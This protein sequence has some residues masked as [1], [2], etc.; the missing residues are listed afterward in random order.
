[1]KNNL[2]AMILALTMVL[3]LALTGCSSSKTGDSSTTAGTG[4]SSNA[5]MI[6]VGVSMSGEENNSI[7]VALTSGLE[8]AGYTVEVA[9]T[10]DADEQTKQISAMVEDGAKILIV[11]PVNTEKVQKALESIAVDVSDVV[12]IA[13]GDSMDSNAVNVYVGRDEEEFGKQSAQEVLTRLGLVEDTNDD[14]KDADDEDDGETYTVELLSDGGNTSQ[15]AF[16]SAMKVLKPYVD[17]GKL[18]I[19]SGHTTGSACKTEDV[20]STMKSLLTTTYADEEL[21]AILCL[22]RGQAVPVIETIFSSYQGNVYPVIT[23]G[24]VTTETVQYLSTNLLDMVSYYDQAELVSGALSAVQAAI[25][26]K[27]SGEMSVK[28]KISANTAVTA[29]TLDEKLID[30]GLFVRNN[31]GTFSQN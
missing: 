12:V 23:C 30:S 15:V 8:G 13:C 11:D 7:G 14:D 28:E 17:A 2:F 19:R 25:D 29:D 21:N 5:A 26:A 9:Y 24:D 1:M 31:D 16:N 20:A 22:G 6:M 10:T 18:V 4:G 3:L 27:D